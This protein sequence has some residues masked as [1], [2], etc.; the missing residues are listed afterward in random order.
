MHSL[1]SDGGIA[2]RNIPE[3]LKKIWQENSGR[4]TLALSLIAL[5]VFFI[6]G[7]FYADH[8]TVNMDEGMYLLKGKYFLQGTYHPYQA[9][10]PI[11]NKGVFAFW[12]LGLSQ[13]VAPGLE[14]GRLFALILSTAMLAVMWLL[15][16]RFSSQSWAAGILIFCAANGFWISMYS[17]A[18]TQAV[19][20]SLMV[21]SVYFLVG[22]AGRLWQLSLGLLLAAVISMTRQ[23]LLPYF[24]FAI[25]YLLWQYGINKTWLP[26]TLSIA[27]FVFVNAIYWPD[28]YTTMWRPMINTGIQLVKSIFP[29]AREIASSTPSAALGKPAFVVKLDLIRQ[30]KHIFAA[31]AVYLVP[32]GFA[33]AFLIH[34]DWKRA[35]REKDFKI[36][37]FLLISFLVLLVIHLMAVIENNAIIF[38][39]DLYPG[40]F[41]P[42]GLLIIPW[43][44]RWMRGKGSIIRAGL[45]SALLMFLSTGVGLGLHRTLSDRLMFLEVPRVRNLSI[46]PGTTE[47]WRSLENKF[48]W[49][50]DNLEFILAAVYGF[51]VGAALLLIFVLLFA[52]VRKKQLQLSFTSLL[53]AGSL[54]LALLFSPTGYL[55]GRPSTSLCDTSPVQQAGR[56]GK[57]LA[58]VIPAGSLV[59]WEYGNPALLLYMNDVNLYP[60]QLNGDFYRRIGGDSDVLLAQNYWNDDIA[61]RWLLGA[62]Y[63]LLSE[64]AAKIWE[65]S[66]AAAYPGALD[67][68]M[69]TENVDPCT[70][71]SYIHVYQMIK[72]LP[73][74]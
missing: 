16:R 38:G 23:N 68:L 5:A 72:N 2:V 7:L 45:M 13:L 49:G 3:R 24:L 60:A 39:F 73:Q 6:R 32:I 58:E 42:L 29:A 57:A 64:N 44:A 53:T 46:L 15:I 28:S 26:I 66:M 1:K 43:C 74:P 56:T 8:M 22:K 11:T 20:A 18:L 14:S 41:L 63:A 52:V 54:L 30:L 50:Y 71:R 25:L 17:R 19:T 9:G 47:L 69:V 27:F 4:I 55:A 40:F 61:V 34:G 62:D 48:H 31:V 51:L 35:I 12:I 70:D 37:L 67:K 10:G 65:Q 21:F 36:F 59:Y 33:A